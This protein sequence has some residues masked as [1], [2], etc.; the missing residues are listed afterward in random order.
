VTNGKAPIDIKAVAAVRTVALKAAALTAAE[1]EGKTLCTKLGW[2]WDETSTPQSCIARIAAGYQGSVGPAGPA[3]DIG[4]AGAPGPTGEAGPRGP[5]GLAYRVVGSKTGIVFGTLIGTE[6]DID[7]AETPGNAGTRR[8]MIIGENWSGTDVVV[9]RYHEVGTIQ[10]IDVW[11]DGPNCT[12]T[13]HFDE[14]S[15]NYLMNESPVASPIDGSL[16]SFNETTEVIV[17]TTGMRSWMA[18]TNDSSYWCRDFASDA[19]APKPVNALVK[20]TRFATPFDPILTRNEALLVQPL[21]K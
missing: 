4:P 10:S 16:W 17:V 1:E 7:P 15:R 2:S 3:G 13:P 20:M 18:G 19:F 6:S 11:F 21:S 14:R 12:G 9:R 5:A 8:M